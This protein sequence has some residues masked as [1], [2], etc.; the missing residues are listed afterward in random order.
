MASRSLTG[1]GDA[2][3]SMKSTPICR[4]LIHRE[5]ITD[6]M[7]YHAQELTHFRSMFN[8]SYTVWDSATLWVIVGRLWLCS[9]IIAI[10]IAVCARD[11]TAWN[12]GNFH[13]LTNF[14]R[15]FVGFLLGFFMAA[16]VTRW[17]ACIETFISLCGTIRKLQMMLL[18]C[19]AP[20]EDITKV[21]RYGVLS[22]QLLGLELHAQALPSQEQETALVKGWLGLQGDEHDPSFSKLSSQEAKILQEISDPASALW[23][24][25]GTFLG[26]VAAS[27]RVRALA[28]PIFARCMVLSSEGV[29][30]ILRIRS[31]ITIQAPFVYVQM[32]SSLVHISN[33]TCAVSCGLTF[34]TALSKHLVMHGMHPVTKRGVTEEEAAL[35]MQALVVAAVYWLIGPLT[36]Q[37]LLEVSLAIAQPFSNSKALPPTA[38]MIAKLQQNLHDGM[39]AMILRSSSYM[40]QVELREDHAEVDCHAEGDDHAEVDCD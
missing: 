18:A 8:Y 38:S 15:I 29:D 31:C 2:L 13:T 40:I 1:E 22:V 34:G 7:T 12:A 21:L 4:R 26:S 27:G 14:L 39:G 16:S 17:W 32:L 11:P 10:T 9:C 36:Y 6:A 33:I 28:G 25:I 5:P 23:V 35:D 30:K 19:D 37:A 3:K 20:I 24:W